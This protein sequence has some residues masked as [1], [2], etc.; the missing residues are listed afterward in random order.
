MR[1]FLTLLLALPAAAFAQTP[2]GSGTPPNG[3]TLFKTMCAGCHN[4]LPNSRAPAPETLKQRSPEAI[5]EILTNGA[6]RSQ[7][8]RLDGEQRHLIAEY[9]SGKPLGGD[10]TG[11]ATGKCTSQ[12]KFKP[13]GPTW[14]GW[15]VNIHNTRFQPAKEAGLTAAQVPHLEVQ[16]AFGFPDATA[17][18]APP[19]VVGGRV[20]VGSQNGMVYSLDAKSGCIYW[21]FSASGGV[22]TA[23]TVG[24]RK[25]GG[26]AVYFGDTSA[27]AYALDAET[28]KQLWKTKVDDHMMARITG[29]PTLY[30]DRLYVP[31]SSYEESQS[32][33]P[34]YTCCTFRGNV[35]ALDANTGAII[36]HT[37]LIEEEPKEQ[38]KHPNGS[39]TYGP[40]GVA[41]WSAPTVDEKRNLLYV[42]TGNEYTSPFVP[43]SD[44]VVAL[45]L[46]SGKI[47]WSKQ[48]FEKDIFVTK[49]ADADPACDEKRGPDYD[50]GNA[51]ILTQLPN[52]KDA[53]VVGQKSGIGW[54]ID[55]D[56]QG[57]VLWQ[58][59]AG[60]GSALGGME[61]GS[62]VDAEHAYFPVSDIATP[63]PGGLHAVNL[64]TGERVWFVPPPPPNPGCKAPRGCNSAIAAAITVIPG[65]VFAGANDGML[66]AYATKD[67]AVLW[68][69]NTNQEFKTLNGVEA[70]G[71]SILGPGPTVAGGMVY[72]SSG[73]G[74]F[75]G[76]P[77]NVLI[78]YGVKK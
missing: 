18:W 56:K 4:G 52:K 36:W 63:Q 78:A 74:A 43:T 41:I 67:G 24:P 77:G 9:V 30:R 20:F 69:T 7:G 44:G 72:V 8:S 66:R 27:N 31:M 76:R 10:L 6:M 5:L 1:I 57:E 40:S 55:P 28:G 68:E 17:A 35:T 59:R 54:A 16:W 38:A 39:S 46:A 62:A 3:E 34:D 53:I 37:Y 64:Q 51:P 65:V 71:A 58:Y 70:K 21:Y 42:S 33:N 29:A 49:C 26:D 47:A 75:G 15:G 19:V 45:D 11:A 60:K 48:L 23:I 73:Y 12:S 32:R 22:R 13:G 2:A 61:W 14:N 25:G 50:M